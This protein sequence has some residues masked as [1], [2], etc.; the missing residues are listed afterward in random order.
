MFDRRSPY[1]LRRR[2]RENELIEKS[3]I[4]KETVKGAKS[5]KQTE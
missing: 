3:K 1:W 4:L 2:K 5:A